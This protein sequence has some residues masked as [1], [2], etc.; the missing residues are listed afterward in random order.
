MV[1]IILWSG[2]GAASMYLGFQGFG[3]QGLPLSGKKRLTGASGKV[4]G[5]ICILFGLLCFAFLFLII[6]ARA[7]RAA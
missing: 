6:Y 4:A 2:L 5:T 3:A 7:S 1:P